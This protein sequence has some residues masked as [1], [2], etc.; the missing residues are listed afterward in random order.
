V[1]VQEIILNLYN[2]AWSILLWFLKK[3]SAFK[4]SYEFRI[5]PDYF[6]K[7]DIWIHGASV[8]E[9]FVAVEIIKRLY[10][11]KLLKIL[12]TATTSQGLGIMK[13]YCESPEFDLNIECQNQWFPFDKPGI[14]EKVILKTKPRLMV[15]LETELWPGHL[16]MLK[17]HHI[18]TIII[19]ARL[20]KTSFSRYMK[21]RFIWSKISPEKIAATSKKDAVRFERI[22]DKKTIVEIM[23]NIKFESILVDE[24]KQIVHPGSYLK[25]FLPSDIPLS[26]L[27][28]IRK[29]EE[30][31]M[32]QIIK[33][34]FQNYPD[35]VIAI[36]PKHIQR[37]KPLTEQLEKLKKEIGFNL[38]IRSQIKIRSNSKIDKKTIILWDTFG[39]LK[40]AYAFAVTAFVGGSL[41]PLGG[42][43]FLEPLAFG[44]GIVT[45]PYLNSFKWVDEEIFE[46][47][48][49]F[50]AKN[51][52]EVGIFMKKN[53]ENP[54]D[55]SKLAKKG[56]L[57][58]KKRQGGA[59]L[60]VRLI[61]ETLFQ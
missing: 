29:E 33:Y 17:K 32:I 11:D 12:Y 59:D 18:K 16:Y 36:F 27:A 50:K 6:N 1:R 23:P 40:Y 34:L 13:S 46:S 28:S 45:G 47:K 49:V 35:Q 2:F 22:M 15:L 7:A 52:Q 5:S 30:T 4:D 8:G 44:T 19:N 54:P 41:E 58:I 25:N 31:H 55:K 53:L 20:S 51:A 60:A 26:I 21:T 3:S 43:N 61:K 10:P 39:E 42:Q 9:A 56:A 57:F 48:L 14:I 37:M 24:N 38:K